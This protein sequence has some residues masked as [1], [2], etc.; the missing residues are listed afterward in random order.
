ML[1]FQPP[2]LLFPLVTTTSR[3]SISRCTASS[4]LGTEFFRG[5]FRIH[6]VHKRL[7]RQRWGRKRHTVW[8]VEG[9]GLSSSGLDLPIPLSVPRPQGED[10]QRQ[11]HHYRENTDER[12]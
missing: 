1:P 7:G 5:R 12:R 4:H 8:S 3:N 11:A 2:P 6:L 9:S 10:D